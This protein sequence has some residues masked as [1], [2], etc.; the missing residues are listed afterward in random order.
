VPGEV[1]PS[2]GPLGYAAQ[3]LVAIGRD[4]VV[5]YARG[6]AHI[7]ALPPFRGAARLLAVAVLAQLGDFA[8]LFVRQIVTNVPGEGAPGVIRWKKERLGDRPRRG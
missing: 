2:S 5:G 4:T 3:R 8:A 1:V 7:R 6:R